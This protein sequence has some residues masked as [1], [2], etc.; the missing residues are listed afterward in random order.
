[1]AFTSVGKHHPWQLDSQL[2]FSPVVLVPCMR[3]L[4]GRKRGTRGTRD[5][6]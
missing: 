3:V 2:M 4:S 1:M 5:A 6:L